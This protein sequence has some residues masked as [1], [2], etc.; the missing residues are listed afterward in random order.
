MSARA[1]Q[2]VADDVLVVAPIRTSRDSDERM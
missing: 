2:T 1:P